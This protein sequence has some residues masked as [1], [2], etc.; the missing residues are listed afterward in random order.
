MIVNSM[1]KDY[2]AID[3]EKT[4]ASEPSLAYGGYPNT[5]VVTD[6]LNSDHASQ[7]RMTVDEYFNKL[8]STVERRYE[9]IQG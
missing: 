1:S 2:K 4:M 8:W 7:G 9:A 6:P 3:E 5:N